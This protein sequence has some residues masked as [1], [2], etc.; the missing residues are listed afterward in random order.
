MQLDLACQHTTL[1]P[2][3]RQAVK[4]KFQRL[5]HHIDRP[6]RAHVVLTVDSG[7]HKVE[8]TLHG[9]GDP[10]HAHANDRDMYAALDKLVDLLDRRWRKLKTHRLRLTRGKVGGIGKDPVAVS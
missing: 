10:V 3:L 4:E 5:S 8:A 2:S 7:R 6:L 1:T 9:A